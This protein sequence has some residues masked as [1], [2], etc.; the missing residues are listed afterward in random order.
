MNNMTLD[1]WLNM[2][3]GR[4]TGEIKSVIRY[5]VD[6]HLSP[7]LIVE[8]ICA[9]H[10]VQIEAVFGGR[11]WPKI[12]RARQ[13]C[14]AELRKAGLSFAEIG[15]MMGRDTSTIHH[16]CRVVQSSDQGRMAAE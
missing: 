12:V 9:Q 8:S 14:Y 13:E 10:G 15:K 2:A 7:M 16:G 11:R 1:E 4:V 6:Q 5:L 3:P